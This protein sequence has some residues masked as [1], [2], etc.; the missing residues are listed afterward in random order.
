ML[1]GHIFLMWRSGSRRCLRYFEHALYFHTKLHRVLHKFSAEKHEVLWGWNI[2]MR[3]S[4]FWSENFF[5][6][7]L[8]IFSG[9][10]N[11]FL[12]IYRFHLTWMF[13]AVKKFSYDTAMARNISRNLGWCGGE[14]NILII[15]NIPRVYFGVFTKTTNIIR[16]YASY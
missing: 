12:Y 2:Q 10:H 1:S 13:V 15:G 4:H 5:Q 7:L 3:E 14:G 8:Q 16:T 11:Y 6:R 9:L